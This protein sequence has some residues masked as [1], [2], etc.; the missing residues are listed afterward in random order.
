MCLLSSCNKQ[1][2]I[3]ND[4]LNEETE[5]TESTSDSFDVNV[6][7][8]IKVE[9]DENL[10]NV[11]PGIIKAAREA[12]FNYHCDMAKYVHYDGYEVNKFVN[13]FN[14]EQKDN[15]NWEVK[16]RVKQNEN[17]SRTA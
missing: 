14:I 9:L 12:M 11:N 8:N 2:N 10:K 6:H 17:D 16:Y 13:I 3:F 7:I 15:V 4:N 5:I 1:E